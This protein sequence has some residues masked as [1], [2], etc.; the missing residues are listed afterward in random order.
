MIHVEMVDSQQHLIEY[1]KGFLFCKFIFGQ[2]IIV[3]LF[4]ADEL[5]YHI[6]VF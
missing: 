4:S 1:A 3:E 2:K 5:G 6:K